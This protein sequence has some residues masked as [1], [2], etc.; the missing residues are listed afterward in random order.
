MAVTTEEHLH[1]LEDYRT[2]AV[3]LGTQHKTKDMEPF[4][5][6]VRNDGLY[7]LDLEKTDDRIRMASDMLARH[8]PEDILVVSS[9]QYGHKPANLF[10]RI[11]EGK[12]RTGRFIPGTLTNPELEDYIEPEIVVATDPMGDKQAIE[13]A[14]NVGIPVIALCDSN[15]KVTDVDL[16]I[17]VNNKGRNALAT[18][19]WLLA[20]E[21][22]RKQGRLP[23]NAAFNFDPEDFEQEL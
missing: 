19:Y 23:E 14:T 18:V 21:T 2:A 16:V 6:K 7:L 15:N 8:D 5:E 1:P 3:H 9:R 17:P 11:V 12:S 22:A 10:A 4:I 13:E 20:R